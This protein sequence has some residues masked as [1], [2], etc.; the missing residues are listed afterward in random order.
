PVVEQVAHPLLKLGLQLALLAIQIR[1][2]VR[3]IGERLARRLLTLCRHLLQCR[4]ELPPRLL[5]RAL[6]LGRIHVLAPLARAV[7]RFEGLVELLDRL[8]RRIAALPAGGGLRAALLLAGLAR[9]TLLTR[10]TLLLALL[11]LLALLALLALL[12]LLIRELLLQLLELAPELLGLPA[13]LLLLPTVS[14]GQ[15]LPAIRLPREILLAPCKLLQPPNRLVD[16]LGLLL[17]LI[18]RDRRLGFVLVLLEIH[19]ELEEL[20]QIATGEPAAAPAAVLLERDL[21]V[22]ELGLRAQQVLQRLL[23]GCDRVVELD[24]GEPLR[25]RVHRLGR[26]L[27][28]LDELGDAL[29]LRR[30]LPGARARGRR[31]AAR[32][33]SATAP[34]PARGSGSTSRRGSPSGGAGSRPARRRHR[35]RH[36]RR[37]GSTARSAARMAAPR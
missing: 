34:R 14:L 25:G 13:Q 6:R 37:P 26:E 18:E 22:G 33:D 1:R 8:L 20:G 12:L 30:Q 21:D 27:E 11:T 7:H 31:A 4:L 16:A 3:E 9:L 2:P 32:R 5:D 17:R 35:R 19:L 23:L 24:L 29:V 36:R 15:L 10:L 28:A